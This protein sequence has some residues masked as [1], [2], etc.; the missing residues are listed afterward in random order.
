MD[1]IF[2]IAYSIYIGPAM[3]PAEANDGREKR[4]DRTMRDI[5]IDIDDVRRAG[6][7]EAAIIAEAERLEISLATPSAMGGQTSACSGPGSGWQRNV[8]ADESAA[9]A[10]HTEV[11]AGAQPHEAEALDPEDG[12]VARGVDPDEGDEGDSCSIEWDPGSV[13]EVVV[14][15]DEEA[16]LYPSQAAAMAQSVIDY[17]HASSDVRAWAMLIRR[18]RRAPR[19]LDSIDDAQLCPECQEAGL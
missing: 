4:K 13:V 15:D 18:I 17:H 5:R 12:R 10:I 1:L 6:T 7:V 16:I 14:P 8:D 19:I 11:A 9:A 2:A 3:G